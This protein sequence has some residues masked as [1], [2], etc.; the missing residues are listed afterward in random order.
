MQCQAKT[1]CILIC[2]CPGIRNGLHQ[3]PS[4]ARLLGGWLN[5]HGSRVKQ[6][7]IGAEYDV[8]LV[9]GAQMNDELASAALQDRSALALN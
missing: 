8:S 2:P 3:T 1:R 5:V 7:V 4:M 6:P 9:G